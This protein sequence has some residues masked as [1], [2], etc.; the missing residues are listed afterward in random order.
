MV[1]PLHICLEFL[2]KSAI[3]NDERKG[4]VTMSIER[5]RA[6]LK[7]FGMEE[8]IMELAES[9]ATVELAAEA[10]HCEPERI[11]KTLSFL[12]VAAGDARIDNHK[13]K[14]TFGTKAKM[15]PAAAVE[16]YI[17]HAVGG[18]CPFGIKEGIKVYLDESLKKFETVFPACGSGNSAIELTIPELEQCSGY[19]EWVN[20]CKEE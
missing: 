20:V 8:R 3:R 14:T 4:S 11:A 17:G 18:V 16:D 12:I 9:S 2:I 6:Y 5:A 15:I 7:E 1:L 19:S 13:Y 10:L